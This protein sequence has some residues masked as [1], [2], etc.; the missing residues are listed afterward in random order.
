MTSALL[1]LWDTPSATLLRF[2]ER[3]GSS[4]NPEGGGARLYGRFPP[5]LRVGAGDRITTPAQ[6][7]GR[8]GPPAR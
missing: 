2:Q 1:K 7:T 8:D 3:T 4:P 6:S 5:P